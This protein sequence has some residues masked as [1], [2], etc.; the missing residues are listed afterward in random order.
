MIAHDFANFPYWVTLPAPE[1][2]DVVELIQLY[3]KFETLL[4]GH[5]LAFKPELD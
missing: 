1:A 2:G 3:C 4:L 5:Y